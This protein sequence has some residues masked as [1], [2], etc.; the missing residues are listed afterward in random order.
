M[1]LNAKFALFSRN[2][3]ISE[4]RSWLFLS[5]SVQTAGDILQRNLW[6][7][8]F[9]CCLKRNQRSTFCCFLN[10][11]RKFWAVSLKSF[12]ISFRL[13]RSIFFQKKFQT[14]SW[15]GMT[16][17]YNIKRGFK[18]AC[19][20]AIMYNGWLWCGSRVFYKDDQRSGTYSIVY[21]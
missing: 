2:C 16:L 20:S 10:F 8:L 12:V 21:Y 4:R 13:D 11:F 9:P 5:C 19:R 15:W 7:Y 3:D 1:F 17:K 18:C 6:S 14:F